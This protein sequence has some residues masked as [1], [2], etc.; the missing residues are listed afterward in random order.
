MEALPLVG[1]IEIGQRGCVQRPVVSMWRTRHADFPA[2][3]AEL[4]IGPVFW[5]PDIDAWLTRTGRARP[6]QQWWTRKQVTGRHR[7]RGPT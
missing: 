2:P 7:Y 3:V 1:L 6:P 5:A 4:A